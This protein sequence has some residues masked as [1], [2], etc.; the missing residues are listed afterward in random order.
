MK[1]TQLVLF[2]AKE[3]LALGEFS[4]AVSVTPKYVFER[5]KD[6]AGKSVIVRDK[7]GNP[8]VAV[9]DAGDAIVGKD[10]I[11]LLPMKSKTGPSFE[12]VT[13]LKGAGAKAEMRKMS[14]VLASEA[15]AELTR[16]V[17]SGQYTFYREE[18][19]RRNGA[20]TPTFR[21]VFGG[22]SIAVADDSELAKELERRGFKVERNP[23]TD[24]GAPEPEQKQLP[25]TEE[26]APPAPVKTKKQPVLPVKK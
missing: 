12:S 21:P 24:N 5:T 11:K 1:Q 4:A 16:L 25:G 2:G 17:S 10:V 7:A 3:P 15:L 20:I 6:A 8:V 9:T 22:K 26:K 13:G 23:A 18:R 14:D 19:N